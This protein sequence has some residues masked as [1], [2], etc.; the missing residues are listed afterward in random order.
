MS[1]KKDGIRLLG[2][3]NAKPIRVPH[4]NAVPRVIFNNNVIELKNTGDKGW[5]TYFGFGKVVKICKSDDFDLVFVDFGGGQEN[6]LKLFFHTLNSRKQLYTLKV[7]QYAQF[8]MI[9]DSK[10]A[11]QNIEKYV[12]L[13]AMGIYVPKMVDIRNSELTQE[14]ITE[15]TEEDYGMGKTFLDMFKKND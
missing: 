15:M 9:R 1:L 11:A 5:R 4:N 13:W 10:D 2:K 14:E 6:H 7:G 3:K 8:G 12:V